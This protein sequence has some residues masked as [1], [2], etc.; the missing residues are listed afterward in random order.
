MHTCMYT[1]NSKCLGLRGRDALDRNSLQLGTICADRNSTAVQ[2]VKTLQYAACQSQCT[3][4]QCMQTL[5]QLML[6]QKSGGFQSQPH[7]GA[8]IDSDGNKVDC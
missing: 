5:M 6:K 1:C 3:K 4:I 2:H 7:T 8:I